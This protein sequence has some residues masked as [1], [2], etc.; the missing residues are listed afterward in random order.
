MGKA[1]EAIALERKHTILARF[2]RPDDWNALKGLTAENP[3]VIDFSQPGMVSTNI[4]N[5]FQYSIP[6][7]VG[8]T[9][10][11][12]ELPAIIEACK[13]GN[14]ALLTAS[15]FSIG[16]NLFF[17]VNTYLASLMDDQLNYEVSIEETHHIHKLD[18]PSGTAITLAEQII[19]QLRRK[20]G[21][22]L[23]RQQENGQLSIESLREGEVFGDHRVLYDSQADRIEIRHTAKNRMGFASGA[24][25]AAEW[26]QGRTGYFEM[27]DF[28]GI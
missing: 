20:K 18:K 6:A 4:R 3:V 22:S 21:W 19:Q 2:D 14:H 24:V 15:N 10:W 8:T 13:K 5:C 1:V 26:I 25:M 11:N 9:G 27:K 16:M 28:L 7:V 23:D 17:A 12:K